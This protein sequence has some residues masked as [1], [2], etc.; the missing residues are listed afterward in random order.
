MKA[1]DGQGDA[2]AGRRRSRETAFPCVMKCS[3]GGGD[4]RIRLPSMQALKTLQLPY[5]VRLMKVSV[6]AD[7]QKVCCWWSAL[8]CRPTAM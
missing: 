1:N 8:L 6:V 5:D 7:E 3:F 4:V 2:E